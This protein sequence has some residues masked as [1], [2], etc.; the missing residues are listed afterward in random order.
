LPSLRQ[1]YIPTSACRDDRRRQ[2][3]TCTAGRSGLASTDA[4]CAEAESKEDGRQVSLWP[5]ILG[6]GSRTG[7]DGQSGRPKGA[8]PPPLGCGRIHKAASLLLQGVCGS[9][10]H[11]RLLFGGQSRSVPPHLQVSMWLNSLCRPSSIGRLHSLHA[12]VGLHCIALQCDL[13]PKRRSGSI[14]MYVCWRKHRHTCPHKHTH[15]HTGAPIRHL[16]VH[17]G[18]CV[19]GSSGTISC[20]TL[21]LPQCS[22]VCTSRNMHLYSNPPPALHRRTGGDPGQPVGESTY[23]A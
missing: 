4:Q 6:R 10:E 18:N 23:A 1:R 22:T 20:A 7:H 8:V 9:V 15:T 16:D 2:S 12:A 3:S 17:P 19:H 21:P 13:S 14:C 5:V 11:Y